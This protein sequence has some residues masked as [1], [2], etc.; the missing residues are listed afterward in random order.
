MYVL[1]E[2]EGKLSLNYPFS[3]LIRT[4]EIS[5]E[6]LLKKKTMNISC[7]YPYRDACYGIYYPH[8]RLSSENSEEVLLISVSCHPTS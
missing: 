8:L 4:T 6:G 3:L 1:I 7:E 2:Q 5:K